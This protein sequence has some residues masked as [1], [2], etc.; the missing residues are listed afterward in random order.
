M[1]ERVRELL[2]KAAEPERETTAPTDVVDVKLRS[3]ALVVI[4]SAC[5]VGL[6]Y[7]AR[8]VFIPIV[9]SVLISYALEPI[10]ATLMR[11]RLPRVAA[12]AIVI[13]LF[14]GGLGYAGYAL[15]DDAA[16]MVA[17]SSSDN[18]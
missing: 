1:P 6:L 11:L 18:A 14:T 17:A 16:A 8:E 3:V 12:A 9:L 7:W 5:A 10:V 15:S 2:H 13:M 4:A